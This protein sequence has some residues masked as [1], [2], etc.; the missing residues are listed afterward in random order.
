MLLAFL[1]RRPAGRAAF[2]HHRRPLASTAASTAA[3]AANDAIT[4]LARVTAARRALR[5]FSARLVGIQATVQFTPHFGETVMACRD[6]SQAAFD[7][8]A[9]ARADALLTAEG[10]ETELREM[11]L[12]YTTRLGPLMARSAA[13][14]TET[15]C[16]GMSWEMS[17]AAWGDLIGGGA[18]P[19]SLGS[20]TPC[21][22]L[23]EASNEFVH[24]TLETK[25]DVEL[26][27]RA[28]VFLR[29]SRDFEKPL[30]LVRQG[31]Q[32]EEMARRFQAEFEPAPWVRTDEEYEEFR[33]VR[34]S[35][36]Q[37]IY[38]K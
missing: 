12:D 10:L 4:P 2:R 27:G 38:R 29:L 32:R 23:F 37:S 21:G 16:G 6:A 36:L 28:A 34:E 17:D 26:G 5:A 19:T 14:C 15:P 18:A 33:K 11:A 13:L 35:L 22:L 30:A 20:V 31:S 25:H 7:D 8:S 24:T 3:S 1:L 9:E